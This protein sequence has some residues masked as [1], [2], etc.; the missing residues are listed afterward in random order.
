VTRPSSQDDATVKCWGNNYY[1]QLGYGDT[2]HRGDG[3]NG[4]CPPRPSRPRLWRKRVVVMVA[5]RGAPAAE[6]G[7]KLPA[8]DLGAGRTALSVSAGFYHTCALLVRCGWEVSGAGARL[9]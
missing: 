4:A 1:G 9:V 6:M 8:V 5:D 2:L 7:A 3:S